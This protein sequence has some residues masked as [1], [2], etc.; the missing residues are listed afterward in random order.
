MEIGFKIDN[1]ADEA[2]YRLFKDG[3]VA[4]AWDPKGK[5]LIFHYIE[6]ARTDQT[7]KQQNVLS[8]HKKIPQIISSQ[9]NGVGYSSS[10]ENHI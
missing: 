3:K 10:K 1:D 9:S 5:D 7:T 8:T 6:N 2:I 4:L